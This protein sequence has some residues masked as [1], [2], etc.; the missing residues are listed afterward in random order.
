MK[1]RQNDS[2]VSNSPITVKPASYSS[3]SGAEKCVALCGGSAPALAPALA[4][5]SGRAGCAEA[6]VK[7]TFDFVS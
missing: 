5:L 6:G 4:L 1:Y 7:G 2:T 3:D